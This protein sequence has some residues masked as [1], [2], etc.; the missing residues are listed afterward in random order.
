M[1]DITRGNGVYKPTNITGDGPAKSVYHQLKVRWFLHPMIFVGLEKPSNPKIGD[2]G[3][4]WPL[5]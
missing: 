1:V 4:R 5:L 3:F 2:A